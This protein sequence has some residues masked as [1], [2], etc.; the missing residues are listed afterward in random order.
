MAQ[1]N[2]NRLAEWVVLVRR[3]WPVLKQHLADWLGACRENP[4][5][6]WATPSVRYGTWLVGGLIAVWFVVWLSGSLVPPPPAAA[7][8]EATTA[9]YHVICTDPD[10]SHH[11]VINRSFGFT[12]FPVDCPKCKREIGERAIRCNSESCQ[13]RWVAPIETDTGSE[14][15]YCDHVFD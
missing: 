10:C 2:P 6:I 5:L 14:C 12:S 13:G 8:P 9:D 7:K 15:P 4:T 11:F 1:E 3:Q